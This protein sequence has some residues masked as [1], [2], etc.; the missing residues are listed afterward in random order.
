MQLGYTIPLQKRLKIKTLSYGDPTDLCFCWEVHI[1][2]LMRH[3]AILAVNASSRYAV[4]LYSVKGSDWRNL[5][6]L[7]TE[8]M[9]TA[10]SL[11]GFPESEINRYF[12]LAGPVEI[13]KTHGRKAVSGLNRAAEY[14]RWACPPLD[15][16]RQYQP[17]A[18]RGMN[19]E[20]CHAA[21]YADYGTP[22]EFLWKDFETLPVNRCNTLAL[23]QR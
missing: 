20:L 21:G 5:P 4:L 3:Q 17:L 22:R 15:M 19:E 13:T 6:E 7:V 14:L 18:S 16:E 9:R 12:T 8:G 1:L 10:F 23:Q 2:T 11:E